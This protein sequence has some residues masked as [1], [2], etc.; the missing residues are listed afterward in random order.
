MAAAKNDLQGSEAAGGPLLTA[1][2]QALGKSVNTL[3]AEPRNFVAQ[4]QDDWSADELPGFDSG[5]TAFALADFW[6]FGL[7]TTDAAEPAIRLRRARK[8]DGT[9]L[10][11]DLLEIVQLDRPFLVD[12]IMGAVAEAGFQVRAMFHPWSRP[13]ASAA[14]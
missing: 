12:S 2:A 3:E 1:F 9:D 10:R 7:E 6:R 5:D 14:R 13:A 4:A 11:G 8:P